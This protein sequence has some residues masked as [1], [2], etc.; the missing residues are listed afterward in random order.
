MRKSQ[1]KR[2]FKARSTY[3]LR[4][5]GLIEAMNQMQKTIDDIMGKENEYI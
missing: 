5:E 2:R 4:F 3:Y 1:S